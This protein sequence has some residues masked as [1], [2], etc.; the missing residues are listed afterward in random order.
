VDIYA[1]G[2]FFLGVICDFTADIVMVAGKPESKTGR[3]YRP[4][5]QR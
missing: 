3:D 1:V 4:V 2:S 5:R